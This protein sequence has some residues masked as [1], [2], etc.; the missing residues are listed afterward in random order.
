MRWRGTGGIP[1]CRVSTCCGPGT[2][3]TFAKHTHNAYTIALVETGI[4]VWRERSSLQRAGPG[5]MPIVNPGTLHTGHAGTPEGWTYRVLYPA[6]EV[7][8]GVA[9]ELGMGGGSPHFPAHVLDDEAVAALLLSAHRA[10]EGGD[11][12]AASSLTRLL[13]ARMLQRYGRAGAH[14]SHSGVRTRRGSGAGAGDPARPA[15]R[16]A[17]P[18]DAGRIRGCQ[19]V[20]P[21]RHVAAAAEDSDPARAHRC[22]AGDVPGCPAACCDKGGA[23][24]MVWVAIAATA[25]GCYAWK[26]LGMSVPSWLLDRPAV[27][28]FAVLAPVALLAALTGVQTLVAG[29]SIVIDARLGGLAAAAVLLLRARSWWWWGRPWP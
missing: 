22:A 29:R 28:R 25:A 11:A 18:R 10:A 20:F 5:G 7:V 26:A 19:A 12:V 23:P 27:R 4:E 1:G 15:D 14:R 16:A 2:S 3:H 6:P 24:M 17:G 13:L 8:A 9:A 21:G